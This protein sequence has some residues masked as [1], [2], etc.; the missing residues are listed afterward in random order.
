MFA[1]LNEGEDYISDKIRKIF[2]MFDQDNDDLISID[3]M[4][5]IFRQ[6]G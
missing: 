1:N 5:T 4:R 6:M 3:E 2:K